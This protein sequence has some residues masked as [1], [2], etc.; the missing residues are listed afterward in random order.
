MYIRLW[1]LK[2]FKYVYLYII[3]IVAFIIKNNCIVSKIDC[4]FRRQIY[5]FISYSW[6]LTVLI[7]IS[8]YYVIKYDTYYASI[9]SIIW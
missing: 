2:N 1:Q 7:N 6:H 3:L 9:Y 4:R 5:V 8:D